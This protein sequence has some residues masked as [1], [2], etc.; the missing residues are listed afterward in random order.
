M[1]SKVN[2]KVK[3]I[4]Q[5]AEQAIKELLSDED[6]VA[7][8]KA[9]G[10]DPLIQAINKYNMVA[11]A[12]TKGV[13]EGMKDSSIGLLLAIAASELTDDVSKITGYKVGGKNGRK[14]NRRSTRKPTSTTSD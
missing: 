3:E 12:V 6:A 9:I 4:D 10:D 14:S 11:Y 8:S 7:G 2:K 5:Q 13:R 1:F